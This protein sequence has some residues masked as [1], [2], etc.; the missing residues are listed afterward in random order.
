MSESSHPSTTG[1]PKKDACGYGHIRLD[2]FSKRMHCRHRVEAK[3]FRIQAGEVYSQRVIETR[4]PRSFT[5]AT[6]SNWNSECDGEVTGR[7]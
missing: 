5:T 6:R 2:D 3:G 7:S 1:S 4:P